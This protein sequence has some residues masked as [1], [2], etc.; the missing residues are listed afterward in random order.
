MITAGTQ[1][2]KI[3]RR[4]VVA[5]A[6]FAALAFA[7]PAHA[8]STETLGLQGRLATVN[9]A[10]VPDGDY[11]LTIAFYKNKADDKALY[12][13]V[14]PAVKVGGGLFAVSI[15]SVTPLKT[16]IFK[17]GE[18][19]WVGL[20]VGSEGELPRVP[21]QFAPYAVRALTSAELLCTGCVKAEHL[22]ADVLKPF[23]KDADL[24]LVA[25][26]GKYGD[27]KDLPV[28]AGTGQ[29]C[30]DGQFAT[31]IDKDGKALCALVPKYSGKD[32]ALASQ[33]CTPG[34]VVTGIDADGKPTCAV[35]ATGKDFALAN[36]AWPT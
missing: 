2:G 34:S 33:A 21:L 23:A 8:D 31:G 3:A 26:S 6:V 11:G 25:K 15:G 9:G 27:L 30:P 22:H 12:T 7:G 24:A 17:S 10:P 16:D 36:Q 29:K 20:T 14:K 5:G 35:A 1:G 13:D 18:A 19:G 32:F 28:L 4:A